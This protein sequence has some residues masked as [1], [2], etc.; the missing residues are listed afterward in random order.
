MDPSFEHLIFKLCPN[1]CKNTT[2]KERA[3]NKRQVLRNII[4]KDEKISVVL[5]YFSIPMTVELLSDDDYEEDCPIDVPSTSRCMKS[6]KKK[7]KKFPMPTSSIFRRF[8][9]CPSRTPLTVF[10]T[11]IKGK[12]NHQDDFTVHFVQNLI[13]K[14]IPLETTLISLAD[15]SGWLRK[16]PL[17]LM[18]TVIPSRERPPVLE[19]EQMPILM[20]EQDPIRDQSP[21]RI[22]EPK[23]GNYFVTPPDL[24]VDLFTDSNGH[25]AP[26]I[27]QKLIQT[28][29]SSG[30]KNKRESDAKDKPPALT[31]E[32]T[33]PPILLPCEPPTLVSPETPSTSVGVAQAVSTPITSPKYTAP[34]IV[35][36]ASSALMQQIQES[37][38]PVSSKRPPF[39]LKRVNMDQPP[40][41]Q[42]VSPQQ[43][44]SPPTLH[45]ISPPAPSNRGPPILTRASVGSEHPMQGPPVLSPVNP[46]LI[47]IPPQ[48]PFAQVSNGGHVPI[49]IPV[50][51]AQ[52]HLQT[53]ISVQSH[54]HAQVFAHP[55][56][57]L[58]SQ[59]HIAGMPQL[60]SS[61][62]Q[63]HTQAHGPA[64]TPAKIISLPSQ[65][66][67]QMP[68]L[69]R[70]GGALS[71]NAEDMQRIQHYMMS[72]QQ[73]QNQ[74]HQIHLQLQ[75]QQGQTV[76]KLQPTVNFSNVHTVK[77]PEAT[78]KPTTPRNVSSNPAT[79][80]MRTAKSKMTK[81]MKLDMQAPLSNMNPLF[82]V[83]IVA[84]SA[85][86]STPVTLSAPAVTTS[87]PPSTRI[88]SQAVNV[89]SES[90]QEL[91]NQSSNTPQVQ[92][93]QKVESKPDTQNS[94]LAKVLSI[95]NAKMNTKPKAQSNS[96][97]MKIQQ[98]ASIPSLAVVPRQSLP[99]A[100]VNRPNKDMKTT[101]YPNFGAAIADLTAR[102]PTPTDKKSTSS[103]VAQI[104]LSVSKAGEVYVKFP[105]ISSALGNKTIEKQRSS[106]QKRVSDIMKLDGPFPKMLKTSESSSPNIS[107][108]LQ[109]PPAILVPPSFRTPSP[110]SSL[111]TPSVSRQSLSPP[112][113]SPVMTTLI[114]SNHSPSPSTSSSVSTLASIINAPEPKPIDPSPSPAASAIDIIT[115]A[116]IKGQPLGRA[117]K[118]ELFKKVN[119][120]AT[121]PPVMAIANA[122]SYNSF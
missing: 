84:S 38:P 49:Q 50:I 78:S 64:S 43:H 98:Q 56:I 66:G 99:T 42:A 69:Q 35:I 8:F 95:S 87:T 46:A 88:P 12:L 89:K 16:R 14:E 67:G 30:S 4:N 27:R 92:I 74:Q 61:P 33:P 48:I 55:P 23:D 96:S 51:P 54:P 31:P 97:D 28:P 22:Q 109:V 120:I 52:A 68:V 110:P 10:D 80:T 39:V 26:K 103:S 72:Q 45:R 34:G 5:E 25:Q 20:A 83:S 29:K 1:F 105:V 60:T 114:E 94:E 81:K 53:P 117:I 93:Q 77:T 17:R 57:L 3:K 122:N 6:T 62:I 18:F 111:S 104:P 59:T 91:T 7:K 101:I 118:D 112:K 9:R 85:P 44:P 41:L 15:S 106:P 19:A 121:N 79:V 21:V 86:P 100:N 82:P 13:N 32:K 47:S 36:P 116:K 108:D 70:T 71:I 63:I 102:L 65:F 58:H 76:A 73:Q 2:S 90:V 119:P 115:M 40:I 24:N 75:R 107:T 11:L 37:C 113:L